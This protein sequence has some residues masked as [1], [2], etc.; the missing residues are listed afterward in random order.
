MIQEIEDELLSY[1]E[2]L[3]TTLFENKV[4]TIDAYDDQLTD[5]NIKT[6]ALQ[7]PALLFFYRGETTS[8]TS[9]HG[10][11]HVNQQ[12]GVIAVS[13]NVANKNAKKKETF[14]LIKKVKKAFRGT[15]ITIGNRSYNAQITGTQV[16]TRSK[17]LNV[18]MI[19]LEVTGLEGDDSD[20]P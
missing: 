12:W 3:K 17:N 5:E 9:V 13:G 16:V 4:K 1:A 15:I 10:I 8:Q 2:S 19:G 11:D 14:D 6:K 20:N 18:F 7:T